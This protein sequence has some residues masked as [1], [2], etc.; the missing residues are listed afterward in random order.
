MR[1]Q[2][3][4]NF[5]NIYE[6]LLSRTGLLATHGAG[7]TVGFIN[8]GNKTDPRYPDVELHHLSF[9]R[10]QHDFLE[11]FLNGL[12]FEDQYVKH[13]QQQLVKH[14]ILC[15]FVLLSHP[16]SKGQLTLRSRDFREALDWFITI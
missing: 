16:Q 2:L 15:I 8:T 13:L 6:Y 12:S 10:G 7:S 1:R 5:D 11:M 14:N 4:G 9:Q 3:Q